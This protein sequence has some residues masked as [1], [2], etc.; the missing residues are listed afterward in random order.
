MSNILSNNTTTNN[1]QN[2]N[3]TQVNARVCSKAHAAKRYIQQQR[4]NGAQASGGGSFSNAIRLDTFA[5]A[6]Q[7]ATPATIRQSAS[8]RRQS[9]QASECLSSVGQNSMQANAHTSSNLSERERTRTGDSPTSDSIS[10]VS[11]VARLE[12][13]KSAGSAPAAEASS[14]SSATCVQRP[15]LVSFAGST[16]Q[17]QRQSHRVRICSESATS[18]SASATQA[19]RAKV[20][21]QVNDERS[22]ATKQKVGAFGGCLRSS[23]LNYASV[24]LDTSVEIETGSEDRQANAGTKE[25]KFAA[26]S[27]AKPFREPVDR[28]TSS[29][30]PLVTDR[31]R[32]VRPSL[33]AGSTFS[34]QLAQNNSAELHQSATDNANTTTQ[35][36]HSRRKNLCSRCRRH[37]DLHLGRS[38]GAKEL[39]APA[40]VACKTT[41]K[42][43]TTE[44]RCK[45]AHSSCSSRQVCRYCNSD[46]KV[47]K[48]RCSCSAHKKCCAIGCC[49]CNGSGSN[50]AQRNSSR[51]LLLA[52]PDANRRSTARKHIDKQYNNLANEL[53]CQCTSSNIELSANDESL[54]VRPSSTCLMATTT[55]TTTTTSHRR[56]AN[57]SSC[58]SSGKHARST[59]GAVRASAQCRRCLHK[60]DAASST[61]PASTPTATSTCKDSQ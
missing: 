61:T 45:H 46:A 36:K 51:V 6:S 33:V 24:S 47:S 30:M 58:G 25:T 11:S 41:P 26:A 7:S 2:N 16:D 23:H 31:C 10:Q 17:R 44:G 39:S 19:I 55:A 43:P 49:C 42:P 37:R 27:A 15:T 50:A 57:S 5:K 13:A 8:M 14:K 52:P 3:Q 48:Q 32:Q 4:P 29:S 1:N 38:A 60:L 34:R 59:S 21:T 20:A 54:P 18:V 22:S 9:S 12:A 35:K 56:R 40:E 28:R 53:H